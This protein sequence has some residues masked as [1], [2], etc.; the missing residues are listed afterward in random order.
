MGN[1]TKAVIGKW[2][3][4]AVL[5]LA[6]CAGRAATAEE[7]AFNGAVADG[8]TTAMGLAAGAAE[9]NPLG[10][11]LS[12]GMKLAANEYAKSLPEL[13]RPRVHAAAASMWQGAAANNLCVVAAVLS[14][15]SFAPVCVAVGFAW[16][17]KT[18]QATQPER[19]FWEA[20]ALTR[21]V[22]QQPDL[23]CIYV[24]PGHEAALAR[25]NLKLETAQGLVEAH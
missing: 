17:M 15:G 10:P 21:E 9:L 6:A 13:E 23:V 14:G 3:V 12:V 25:A 2:T 8:V 4:G 11:V 20:C 24:P 7:E 19:E 16:G 5:V 22:T 18:W 1:F